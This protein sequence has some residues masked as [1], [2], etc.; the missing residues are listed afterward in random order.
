MKCILL[1]AKIA[2]LSSACKN[3]AAGKARVQQV[4][5]RRSAATKPDHMLKPLLS[6]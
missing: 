4:D 2:R 6:A 5:S 3:P 1:V